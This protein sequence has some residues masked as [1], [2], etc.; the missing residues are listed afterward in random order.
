MESL[1]AIAHYTLKEHIRNRIYLSV[2][3]FGFIL[4]GSS[5]IISALAVEEQVRMMVDVGLAGIEFLALIT[6]LFVTVNLVLEEM[7]SR[8]LYLIL[9]HPVERWQYIV[10]RFLGTIAA[11]TAG[12]LMMA[13]LHVGSLYLAGWRLE[14]F[15][16]QA[17]LCAILKVI[18]IGALALLIS[19]ITTSTASSMTLTGFLWV[20]GHFTS[21]VQFM[22]ERSQ[23]PLVKA[24]GDFLHYVAPNFT[25]FNYRDFWRA[26]TVPPP[27]WFAWMGVYSF[28]YV[29]ISLFLT[30]WV[31]SK[32]EF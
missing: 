31:F 26:A 23:N 25:Y 10:G 3:F 11:L 32:K 30:S 8:S 2:I 5:M 13:L 17:M 28:C 7:E 19:L 24:A 21:E 27:G 6:V 20:L 18:V 12:M 4:I 22:V 29:G 16:P 15:Y 14:A 1:L 9:S